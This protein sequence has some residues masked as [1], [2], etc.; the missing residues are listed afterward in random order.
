MPLDNLFLPF[1]LK[2]LDACLAHSV[3]PDTVA[4]QEPAHKYKKHNYAESVQA[5][6]EYRG[7]G[8]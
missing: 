7:A 5:C 3:P 1:E 6:E 4:D 8:P 2:D